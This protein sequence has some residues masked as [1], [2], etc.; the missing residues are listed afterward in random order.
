MSDAVY[1]V[2]PVKRIEL[3]EGTLSKALNAYSR[4]VKLLPRALK[5]P[6]VKPSGA[7]ISRFALRVI[8]K[9]GEIRHILI[10]DGGASERAVDEVLGKLLEKRGLSFKDLPKAD[11]RVLKELDKAL[12]SRNALKIIVD[13][14]KLVMQRN[15]IIKEIM[16]FIKYLADKLKMTRQE[17]FNMLKNNLNQL[18][19]YISVQ[20][21][22]GGADEVEMLAMRRNLEVIHNLLNNVENLTA[23]TLSRFS[24]RELTRIL[25]AIKN[26]MDVQT[27]RTAGAVTNVLVIAQQEVIVPAAS[28]LGRVLLGAGAVTVGAT[29]G[30]IAGRLIGEHFYIKNNKGKYVNVDTHVQKFFENKMDWA[31]F[32]SRYDT[33]WGS[34]AKDKLFKKKK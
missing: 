31:L 7:G 27:I 11:I 9:L 1:R 21:S 33:E 30:W 19:R 16:E 23:K 6:S 29:V 24:V 26:T 13:E 15:L 28:A 3:H 18:Y 8:D 10:K 34:A 12:T 22:D 17:V 14:V 5:A 25:R 4:T 32:V 20:L 2:T